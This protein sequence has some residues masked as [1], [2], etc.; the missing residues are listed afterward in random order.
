[1]AEATVG[2][3]KRLKNI[4]HIFSFASK[5]SLPFDLIS[6]FRYAVVTGGNKG[7][8]FEV[9]RQLASKGIVVILTSR[10][11]KRGMEAVERLKEF[12]VADYV[13]FHQLDV[14]DVSSIAAA[15]EFIKTKYG[16]LDILVSGKNI[17]PCT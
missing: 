11:E 7:I 5:K 2:A 4:S 6:G 3:T 12:G 1:M 13:V 17:F 14:M 15:V 9:C 16:K 8:G 10:N